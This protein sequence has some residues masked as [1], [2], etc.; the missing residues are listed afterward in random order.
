MTGLVTAIYDIGC[1]IGALT[2]FVFGEQMGRKRS[3]VI[4][5]II[6]SFFPI[7][8]EYPQVIR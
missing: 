6:G 2:A 7:P 5:N 8:K 1:A 3:I 4:A